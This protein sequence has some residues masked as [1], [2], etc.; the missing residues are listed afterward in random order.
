MSIYVVTPDMLD[1]FW[2]L[3]VPLLIPALEIAGEDTIEDIYPQ[4]K[5]NKK[6]LWI[7]FDD[8][9]GVYGAA[10]TSIVQHSKKKVLFLEY[11]GALPNT[12]VRCF[13]D[14]KD[15]FTKWAKHHDCD[16]IELYG[17]KGWE[18]VLKDSGYKTT[19]YVYTLNLKG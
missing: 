8:D 18:R 12:M 9:L 10:V 3:V 5:A 17:R 15:M 19:R 14:A 13:E 2:P 16:S 6:L 7:S 4:L 1:N 11:L